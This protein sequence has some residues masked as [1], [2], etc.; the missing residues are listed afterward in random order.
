M[1]GTN[2]TLRGVT[3]CYYRCNT[4]YRENR[5]THKPGISEV[6]IE[7][8]LLAKIKP[9]IE[10]YITECEAEAA[11]PAS[12][13]KV[14]IVKKLERELE[15]LNYQFRKE[16]ITVEEYDRDYEDLVKRINE[17]RAR[18]EAIENP[19][20]KDFSA[21]RKLL[22]TDIDSLYKTFTREEKRTPYQSGSLQG[23]ALR[24]CEA[25]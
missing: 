5:C 15:R 4:A 7:E 3:Y 23:S 13:A 12:R 9:E 25:N 20:Q 8:Y 11:K 21:L 6:K 24:V 1:S 22:E 17:A 19:V 18:Q 16:R 10:S 2:T 14:D